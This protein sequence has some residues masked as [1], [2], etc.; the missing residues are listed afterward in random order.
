MES[1]FC[2]VTL[3]NMFSLVCVLHICMWR[4]SCM[5]PPHIDR[6]QGPETRYTQCCSTDASWNVVNMLRWLSFSS[7]PS[8]PF[9][10][11]PWCW[12]NFSLCQMHAL[13]T[14]PMCSAQMERMFNTTRIP[15]IET[16]RQACVGKRGNESIFGANTHWHFLGWNQSPFTPAVKA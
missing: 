5:W 6:L 8:R 4:I 16:G 12:S 11:R 10:L 15:G 2:L 14:V 13:G 7:N 1:F 9:G 3:N